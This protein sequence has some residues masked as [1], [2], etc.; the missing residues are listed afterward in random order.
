MAGIQANES[1]EF[2]GL[3]A[4]RRNKTKAVSLGAT[5]PETEAAT[6]A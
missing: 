1:L 4:A 5:A 3:C 6:V 2:D